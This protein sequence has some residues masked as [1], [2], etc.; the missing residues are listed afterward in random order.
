[1]TKVN[2]KRPRN[3]SPTLRHGTS[4]L[5]AYSQKTCRNVIRC[6]SRLSVEKCMLVGGTIYMG[7]RGCFVTRI[8]LDHHG[9]D[10]MS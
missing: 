5:S 2:D 1:M 3:F 6:L 4:E 9:K 10:S 8:Y 7:S